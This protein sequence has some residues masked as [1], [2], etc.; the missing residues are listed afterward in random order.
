MWVSLS[1]DAM[2]PISRQWWQA[3][4]TGLLVMVPAT[5][6]LLILSKLFHTLDHVTRDLLSPSLTGTAPGVGFVLL[7]LL[8]LLTGLVTSHFLGQRLVQW[9]EERVGRIPLVRTIYLTLKS[10]TDLFHFRSRFGQSMVVVFPFPREGLWAIGFVMGAAPTAV[11]RTTGEKLAMLFVPTA[12]HPFTGYLAFVPTRAIVPI[13]LP[14]DEAMK[15]EF[16]AGLYRPS[17]AWLRSP[18]SPEPPL[19]LR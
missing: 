11:Q 14:V 15:L 9:T 12:I 6:T 18:A 2:N 4:W 8:I 17:G 16:S 7:V 10:M 19:P 1:V 13:N 3:W 5:A